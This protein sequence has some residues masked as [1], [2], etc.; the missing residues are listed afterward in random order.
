[1]AKHFNSGNVFGTVMGE[2]E[3]KPSRGGKEFISF[4]VNA[5]GRRC[6]S[7]RAF[8]RMWG[9]DR[10]EDFLE[11]LQENPRA[12]FWF[13]GFFSHYWTDRNEIHANY[14]IYEWHLREGDPRAAFIL[15][16]EVSHAM[17]VKAGQRILLEVKREGQQ[18]EKFELISQ[19][20]KLLDVPQAGD[21]IEVKGYLRQEHPEDDFGGSSGA[22]RSFVEELRIIEAAQA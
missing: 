21:L 13:R 16:G 18:V 19:A 11:A 3:R 12:Q 5:S 15:K 2:I 22:V 10:F 6:G 8:C 17:P 1:M 7:V 20:E 4:E 9:S 14:T